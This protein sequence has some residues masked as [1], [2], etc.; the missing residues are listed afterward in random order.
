M[1]TFLL[2]GLIL[3]DVVAVTLL[4]VKEQNAWA[5]AVLALSGVAAWVFGVPIIEAVTVNWQW[6]L[7][8]LAA[9][10]VIGIVWSMV[11]WWWRVRD[12][13]SHLRKFFDNN[14]KP[15]FR[16]PA[17]EWHKA[18][19]IHAE[20]TRLPTPDPKKAEDETPD[21]FKARVSHWMR[22]TTG[23]LIPP[24]SAAGLP[25]E[26]YVD[27]DNVVK[28]RIS[29]GD[30][31]ARIIGWMSLWPFS[32]IG[33]LVDDILLRMWQRFYDLFAG[34]YQRISDKMIGDLNE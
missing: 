8:F 9:Y 16:Q 15:V 10:V 31:K 13:R 23:I 17:D 19:S 2:I 25:V 1:W 21:A 29:A 27:T 11:K 33:T 6:T 5:F 12:A 18:W 26:M 7:G 22:E 30:N 4:T 28:V 3:A 24:Y 34:T 14:P 20:R 32:M